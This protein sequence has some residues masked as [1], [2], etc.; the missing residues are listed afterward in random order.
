[1]KTI[2]SFFFLSV[3]FAH[4]NNATSAI[5]VKIQAHLKNVLNICFIFMRIKHENNYQQQQ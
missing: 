4:W 3:Q 2:I 5:H 1:M